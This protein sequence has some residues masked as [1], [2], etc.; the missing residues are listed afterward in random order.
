MLLHILRVGLYNLLAPAEE[1]VPRE[2]PGEHVTVGVYR[3]ESASVSRLGGDGS[4]KNA[5]SRET[6]TRTF[7]AEAG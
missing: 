1:Q 4:G 5:K 3:G 6:R 7:W 2:S